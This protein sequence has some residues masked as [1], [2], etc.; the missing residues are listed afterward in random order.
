MDIQR[1]SNKAAPGVGQMLRLLAKNMD[2]SWDSLGDYLFVLA[3]A[4][5]QALAMRLFLIPAEL[6]SGGI[7]GTAQLINF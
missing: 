2:F 6:V 5:V 7:S 3:G 4:F 1:A